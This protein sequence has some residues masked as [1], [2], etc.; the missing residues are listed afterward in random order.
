MVAIDGAGT[1]SQV[2]NLDNP[3]QST[4]SSEPAATATSDSE[5]SNA[6]KYQNS[7]F[8]DQTDRLLKIVILER[9]WFLLHQLQ[10]PGS[11][12]LTSTR[13]QTYNLGIGVGW[14]IRSSTG[15]T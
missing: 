4:S 15:M 7:E 8:G 1:D 10:L 2:D 5:T 13:R 12:D 11:Q 9:Q 3:R 14:L 6:G